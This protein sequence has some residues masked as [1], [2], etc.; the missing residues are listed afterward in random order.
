MPALPHATYKTTG[1]KQSV[2]SVRVTADQAIGGDFDSHLVELEGQLIGRDE[3]AIDP[4]IVLS[5]GKLVFSAVLPTGTGASTC[6]S[7]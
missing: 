3:T 5:S 1:T 6:P 2:A 7:G 4:K